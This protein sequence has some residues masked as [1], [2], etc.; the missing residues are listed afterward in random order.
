MKR[1][2]CAILTVITVISIMCSCSSQETV[3]MNTRDFVAMDTVFSLK[4]GEIAAETG[5]VIDGVFDECEKL[6]SDIEN[7]LSATVS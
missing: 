5:I 7:V 4:T 2:I 6:T 3:Q 1:Y